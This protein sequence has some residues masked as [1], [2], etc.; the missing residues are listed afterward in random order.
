MEIP[1]LIILDPSYILFIECLINILLNFGL[2]VKILN[3]LLAAE[4]K[5]YL[6]RESLLALEM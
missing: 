1:K 5:D 6:H 4:R 3:I 2:Q